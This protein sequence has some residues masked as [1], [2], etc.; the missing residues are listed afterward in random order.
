MMVNLQTLGAIDI[1]SNGI[2]LLIMHVISNGSSPQFNKCALIRVP[3]R[4]GA[5]VFTQ[6][7]ISDHNIDR[8]IKA[9]KAFKLLMNVHGVKDYRA[10]ATSAMR[11]ATNSKKV[12]QII[13]REA[14]LLINVIDGKKEAEIIFATDLRNLI[15][16][17]KN[18]FYV[19]VGGGS[20]EF[21][22]FVNGQV[23]SSKSFSIGTVRLLQK[24]NYDSLWKEIKM[25]IQKES[26]NLAQP[27][28]IGSGGNINKIF[29][30]SGQNMG[31]PLSISNLKYQY[32]TY[33]SMDYLERI[34][35]FK[36]NPDRS[37][38]IVH[39]ANIYLKSMKW[40]NANE[41]YIP[42]IGL[43]DGIIKSLHQGDL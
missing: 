10:V 1:G 15:Q 17:D 36:L 9:M 7:S 26:K 18:Y 33:R 41:I 23:T 43:A 6:G 37:D 8:M 29:K 30:L 4:L 40:A 35:T 39:A 13:K 24:K 2:R 25:W 21:T 20:T 42:K 12:C 14:D 3:I 31:T 32:D 16:R 34:K 38:V 5:D 22:V 11:N 28:F 27:I 19:D